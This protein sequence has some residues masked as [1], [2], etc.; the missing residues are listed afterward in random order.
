MKQEI[1]SATQPSP[2][3]LLVV[4]VDIINGAISITKKDVGKLAAI[5]AAKRKGTNR[6]I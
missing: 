5:M 3:P 6:L 4:V 1:P 2:L